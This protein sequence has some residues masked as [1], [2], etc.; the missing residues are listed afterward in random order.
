M[1]RIA[2]ILPHRNNNGALLDPTPLLSAV[3]KVSKGF[4][5]SQRDVLGEWVSDGGKT[6]KDSSREYWT[7]V[8]EMLVPRIL[9]IL[10]SF[11]ETTDEET[12]YVEVTDVNQYFL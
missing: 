8:P 9:E 4:T 7:T 2:W 12:L 3:M 1:K 5:T 10:K 11:R 6:F